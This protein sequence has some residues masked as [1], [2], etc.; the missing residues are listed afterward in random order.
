ML[1]TQL[2][3]RN[4]SLVNAVN[5]NW[6]YIIL[7]NSIRELR[8]YQVLSSKRVYNAIN[9][10]VTLNLV[11]TVWGVRH[12]RFLCKIWNH[13]WFRLDL[14]WFMIWFHWFLFTKLGSPHHMK[15]SIR[16]ITNIYKNINQ[17]LD[18][19][20]RNHC[21]RVRDLES[22]QTLG[23][24]SMVSPS[25]SLPAS[26]FVKSHGCLVHLRCTYI[27]IRIAMQ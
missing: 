15:V 1:S 2:K 11:Y 23:T 3:L 7:S 9:T 20:F 6:L 4:Q 14:Y 16:R 12:Y 27:P 13:L 8:I 5:S 21:N 26:L 19:W 22:S 24:V 18:L 25:T 17:R 10:H